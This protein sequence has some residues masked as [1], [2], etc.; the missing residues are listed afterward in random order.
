MLD[1]RRRNRAEFVALGAA[2][3]PFLCP[4]ARFR[5]LLGHDMAEQA[6]VREKLTPGDKRQFEAAIARFEEAWHAGTPPDIAAFLPPE[7]GPLRTALLQ[8]LIAIDKEFRRAAGDVRSN[9]EYQ[10]LFPELAADPSALSVGTDGLLGGT[11]STE[12]L[13]D[14]ESIADPGERRPKTGPR[15]PL[16][17]YVERLIKSGL[18][19][20]EALAAF[21]QSLP[22]EKQ[23]A[24]DSREFAREL[25]RQK[26][27]TAW[28]A[29]AVLQGKTSALTLGNY[30]ILDKLGEGGM[31]TVFKARHRRMQRTVALKVISSKAIKVPETLRRFLREVEA[32]ARLNHPNIVT[33]FDA[34]ESRGVHFLVMEYVEGTDLASL[35]KQQGPLPVETAVHCI[36][37]AARGLQYAHQ[38]GVTHRDIKPGNLLVTRDGTVK[39]LDMGLARLEGDKATIGPEA[40]LTS[41][42]AVMGTVDYMSPE[43][44]LDTKHADARSDIYSLGCALYHLLTGKPLY[45]ADTVIKK[46]Y[47]HKDQPIPSLR[48]MR[49]DVP[50]GVEAVFRK[51]VAKRPEDRYQTAGDLVAALERCLDPAAS[52]P[53]VSPGTAEETRLETFLHAP[54]VR[55]AGAPQRVGPQKQIAAME[56]TAL[57]GLLDTDPATEVRPLPKPIRRRP[58]TVR[59]VVGGTVTALIVLLGVTLFVRL[60]EVDVKVVIH[61]PGISVRFGDET[62]TFEGSGTP[63]RL[64]PGDRGFVVERDGLEAVTDRFTVKKDGQNLLEVSLVDGKVVVSKNGEKPAPQQVADSSTPKPDTTTATGWHGWP[65]DAPPP[66]IAPF[67][68]AQA[69]QHQEAWAKYLGVPVEYTNSIGMKFR[70][71]PPGEFLMGS[72]D[73]EVKVIAELWAVGGDQQSAETTRSELPQHQVILPRPTYLSAYEVTQADYATVMRRIPSHYASSGGG[74]DDV[75]G[76]DTSRHPVESVTWNEAAAFC[77]KLCERENLNTTYVHDGENM[78]PTK[79]LGYRLPTE[80]EWEF[81]C[82]AG[83]QAP[84]TLETDPKRELVAWLGG[85]SGRRTHAVGELQPNPLGLYDMYGNVYELVQDWWATD[86]YTTFR[87]TPAVD[88]HGAASG[89]F[90]IFRGGCWASAGFSGRASQRRVWMKTGRSR[91]TGFRVALSVDAVKRAIQEVETGGWHGWP[92]DA[93]PAAIAPFDAEQ[94]KAHQEAWAKY[95]GVPVEYTNSI[96]MKF[97]LIPPGEF[98]M[99][100]TPKQLDAEAAAAGQDERWQADIRSEAP[101][102][103]VILTRPFYLGI[104]EVTQMQYEQIVGI[105]PSHF[106]S[107][108]AGREDVGNLDTRNYP[109][110]TVTWNE[111]ADY[112]VKLAELE[113]NTP[114][115]FHTGQTVTAIGGTGYRLPTEAEWEFACRAG[116]S[117]ENWNGDGFASAA[118]IAWFSPNSGKRTHEVGQ[119]SPNPFG[120][121]DFLGNVWEWVED[122]WEPDYYQRFIE[123]PAIDPLCPYSNASRRVFHGGSYDYYCGASHRR[124]SVPSGA[125]SQR[126]FRLAVSVDAVKAAISAGPDSEA[127]RTGWHGWPADAPPPAIAPFDAEQAKLHQEAWANYLGVPVEYTNSIG[128]KFRLIPPG[129]FL[130]GSTEEEVNYGTEVYAASKEDA[131]VIQRALDATRSEL[132]LHQV[133][134]LHPIYIGVCEVTQADY[135]LVTG[136]NPACFAATGPGKEAVSGLDTSRHPVERVSWNDA[137]SFCAKLCDREKLHPTYLQDGEN[138]VASSALGYRLPTEA[139][140][141]FACRAGSQTP[142]TPETDLQPELVGWSGDNSGSRTHAV[143]ELQPSPF[144]LFDMYGNVSEFVQDWWASDYYSQFAT[145]PAVNPLGP[146]SG[147]TVVSRGGGW[148]S[149]RF[150]CRASQR[151]ILNTKDATESSGFRLALTVYSVKQSLDRKNTI[152]AHRW[153]DDAPPPAIAPFDAAQARQHQETWARH[154]GLPVEYTNSI[155]MKF[156]LVPPGEFQMG[157]LPQEIEAAQKASGQSQFWWKYF[158]S[159]APQHK[160]ILTRPIYLGETEVT[161]AQYQRVM[162]TNPSHFCATGERKDAVADVDTQNHPVEMVL[163]SD[164]VDFCAKLSRQEQLKPFYARWYAAVTEL[165]GTGYRLPTEAE[166]E[167]ACRAGTT[168]RFWCGDLESDFNQAGWNGWNSGKHTH[169]VG[170][171]RENPFGLYDVHGNVC[172]WVQDGWD[173]MSYHKFADH[174]AVDPVDTFSASFGGLLRGGCWRADWSRSR[175]SHHQPYGRLG[176][177]DFIGFRVVLVP[178]AVKQLLSDTEAAATVPKT[179]Q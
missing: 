28:Q 157:S 51:M 20:A 55:P 41:T 111:S 141:E 162:G 40:D 165:Q 128:M 66:A 146:E 158:Q 97:R 168:T 120:L 30:V 108:G 2:E 159:E 73:D 5:S 36:V 116:T 86:Y 112:C 92:A 107:V 13:A 18:I 6:P 24:D 163:W 23:P 3:F 7:P 161:Q 17:T 134:L 137:A 167:F 144:G 175:S 124:S 98:V 106:S 44:A 135:S 74:K 76:L 11:S 71:I 59:W 89:E 93:P 149:A 29:T 81:A 26:K 35:V 131:G 12:D 156:R 115:Y 118:Q 46:I 54:E 123:S 8:E 60:G 136:T 127:L 150:S 53:S 85:N 58:S 133:V 104:N 114:F 96:G 48:G 4:E 63:I 52:A 166:W 99:G 125:D 75:S 177:E 69:R 78:I 143:G 27:L 139:E 21:R 72:T 174:P 87:D 178:D 70:L 1:R 95:L 38:Q 117:T 64:K 25:V 140:W 119:L 138:M 176:A 67:D 22:A 155:G 129:E 147:E 109:V 153:P 61:D 110:E 77:G 94:A 10:A 145:S 105:N 103:K 31:G 33:A 151:F 101:Q 34:D 170:E 19:T 130:M 49:G 91:H 88:P 16:A 39:I 173:L 42:G 90:V 15:V 9:D 37:Q 83:S 82:R 142:W 62:V 80:A 132:P 100:S 113:H 126:G 152:A 68:A 65:A 164:A 57:T 32:V 179:E 172:E 14:L 171:L 121:Y 45:V 43:Q 102:H 56:Q 79:A 154:L 148:T 160:V 84:W 169:A 50:E 47:A 122:H